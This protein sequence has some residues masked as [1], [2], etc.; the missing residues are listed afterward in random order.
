MRNNGHI[1]GKLCKRVKILFLLALCT[2]NFSVYAQ[3]N[4][5]LESESDDYQN[6]LYSKVALYEYLLSNYFASLTEIAIAEQKTLPVSNSQVNLVQARIYLYFDMDSA[7]NEIFN[8]QFSQQATAD[9]S[10]EYSS[11]AWFELANQ[12]YR[13]QKLNAAQQALDRV[14]ED[15]PASLIAKFHYL[16]AQLLIKQK[17]YVGAEKMKINIPD[18]DIYHRYLSFN[19]ATHALKAGDTNTAIAQFKQVLSVDDSSE[20]TDELKILIDKAN[21]ALGYIYIQQQQNQ[22]AIAAFKR[23]SLESTETESAM[24]GYGWA[25]ANSNN[26]STALAIW[27]RLSVRTTLTPYVREA[28]IAIPYAYEQLG[29]NP[30]AYQAYQVA[31]ARFKEQQQ[32]LTTELKAAELDH[33]LLDML[34][35]GQVLAAI[36]PGKQAMKGRAVNLKFPAAINTYALVASNDFQQGVDDLK[37]L[38]TMIESLL[39]WQVELEQLSV[40]FYHEATFPSVQRERELR[41]QQLSQLKK[42]R[43]DLQKIKNKRYKSLNSKVAERQAA[44]DKA[45][46]LGITPLNDMLKNVQAKIAATGQLKQDILQALTAKLRRAFKQQL[47]HVESYRKNA[48]LALLRLNDGVFISQQQQGPDSFT[49]QELSDRRIKVDIV[50]SDAGEGE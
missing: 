41:Q 1:T 13:K 18:G 15:L 29:D 8:E 27:Q 46:Q 28:F 25:V 14:S 16:S 12:L 2:F 42:Q 37:D 17:D 35:K 6:N 11:S 40:D 3:K 31:L 9:I 5:A 20:F 7:A 4:T 19:W 43:D 44:L 45:E 50:A 21:L 48:Q 24:L 22:Q 36:L 32:I 10:K 38:H 39:K 30:A 49:A 23:I 33:Y 47:S 26:F 34:V